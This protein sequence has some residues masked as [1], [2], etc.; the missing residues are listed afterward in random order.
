MSFSRARGAGP[1]WH[2]QRAEEGP[3]AVEREIDFYELKGALEAAVDAMK[4]GPL[5]S[6]GE[7]KH[8]REGHR[9]D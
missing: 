8:L 1:G 2:G 7:L 6:K 5:G 9:E 4:V 3:C